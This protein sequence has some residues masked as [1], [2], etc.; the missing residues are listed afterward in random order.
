MNL[1]FI[2]RV[3]TFPCS[4]AIEISFLSPNNSDKAQR[5][6]TSRNAREANAYQPSMS[7]SILPDASISERH[8]LTHSLTQNRLYDSRR[9]LSAEYRIPH[10]TF[11]P[12]I[13]QPWILSKAVL[14]R[15][16]ISRQSGDVCI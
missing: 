14:S 9:I 3:R 12:V 10:S 5:T 1:F 2:T 7:L 8:S 6:D 15:I 4:I 11:V 13:P 16:M